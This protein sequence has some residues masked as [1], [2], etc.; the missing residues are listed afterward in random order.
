MATF[1][2]ISLILG[3]LVV[4][5]APSAAE[6]KPKDPMDV[7]KPL[8]GTWKTVSES[9]PSLAN[10]EKSSG[11]GEFTGKMIL[12]GRFF[13]LD[14][15]GTSPRIGRQEYQLLMTYDE[16]QQAY[17]RW[18]FRSDGVS[19]E[20]TGVWNAEKKQFTWSTLG[21]P[22]NATFTVTTTIT[23]DGFQEALLGKRADGAVSMD[24]TMTAKKKP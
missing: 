17:R 3:A 6:D 15:Y 21:L 16:R 19:A 18:V 4:M 8:V 12:G 20:S 7:F 5:A 13:L 1:Y 10:P 14:G 11:A 2:T 24:L 9:R 22:K 23:A